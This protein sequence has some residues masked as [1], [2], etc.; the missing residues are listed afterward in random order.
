MPPN[1]DWTKVRLFRRLGRSKQDA[2][3]IINFPDGVVCLDVEEASILAN[4]FAA[5][6]A[7]EIQTIATQM[8]A[9]VQE[10]LAYHE[11]GQSHA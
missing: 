7:P 3:V 8:R 6:P 10:I 9:A 11:D 1:I 4:V 2:Q 5:M